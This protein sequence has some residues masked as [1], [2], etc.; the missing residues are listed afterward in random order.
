M[1]AST[2]ALQNAQTR[3][4]SMTAASVRPGLTEQELS[5]LL[6]IS[7]TP[8]REGRPAD[9]PNWTGGWDLDYAAAEGWRWK[10]AAVA[11]DFSFSADDASYQKDTVMAKCLAMAAAFAAK[12]TRSAPLDGDRSFGTY[13]SPGL[14]VNG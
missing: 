13:T 1:A 4:S 7:V 9:D 14:Q 5:T 2:T 8:D 3:L 6:A 10:A 11:A 12:T